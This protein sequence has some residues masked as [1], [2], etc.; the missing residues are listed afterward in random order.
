MISWNS[1]ILGSVVVGLG[2]VVG[3]GAVVVG[4]PDNEK[5]STIECHSIF[6]NSF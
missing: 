1:L 3:F 4:A 5:R 6:R 2:V